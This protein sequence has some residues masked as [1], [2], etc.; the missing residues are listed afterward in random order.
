MWQLSKPEQTFLLSLARST[1]EAHLNDRLTSS[2]PD[3]PPGPL[4]AFC[5]AFVTL[6]RNQR[7]RGCI[8]HTIA[9][10]PLFET[11]MDCAV[12]AATQDPRFPP[13]SLDELTQIEIEISVLSPFSEVKDVGDIEV[14]KHGLMISRGGRHGLLLPQ[15]ATEYHLTRDQFLDQTCLK[16]G[17]PAQAWKEAGTKITAFTA[18]VFGEE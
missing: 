9:A 3:V 8:G 12:A 11:I 15:V 5:S 17:L 18:F 7:L 4:H 2:P 14:G 6:T 10:K 13:L 1:I 16:A